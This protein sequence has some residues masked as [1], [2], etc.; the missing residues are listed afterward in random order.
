[1]PLTIVLLCD[2]ISATFSH[3]NVHEIELLC[4]GN[5]DLIVAVA[6]K[7][8][9]TMNDGCLKSNLI[10]FGKTPIISMPQ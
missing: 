9:L 5:T 8:E 1:M 6:K 3:K 4:R 7:T 10:H 2:S